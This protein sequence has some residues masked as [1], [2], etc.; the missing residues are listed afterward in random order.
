MTSLFVGI[1]ALAAV[2]LGTAIV[3]FIAK[4]IRYRAARA[5]DLRRA[6]YINTLSELVSRFAIPDVELEGWR[7]DPVFS[8][9]LIEALDIFDG[10]QRDHLVEIARRIG[11]ADDLLKG[12]AS[13]RV[14]RRLDAV[15]ALSRIADIEHKAAIERALN[16]PSAE[17]RVQAAFALARIGSSDSVPK[18]IRRM[19]SEDLWAAQLMADALTEFGSSA[20][21]AMAADVLID[22]PGIE[23]QARYLPDLVRALGSIGDP[24][25]EP[26]L[27][28]A[29]GSDDPIIRLRAAEALGSSGTPTSVPKLMRTLDDDDW[30]VRVKAAAALGQQRD[31]R[32]LMNLRT[33]LR[34]PEWWVRQAA[35]EAIGRI[36]GGDQVLIDALDDDDPF[37][38]DAAVE[39]LTL[40]GAVRQARRAGEGD[41]LHDKLVAMGRGHL[42][43]ES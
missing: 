14:G 6:I 31:A 40:T 7:K 5:R 27:L 8:E 11:L 21:A 39:R 22:R 26:A 35:A 36:G 42:V 19:N 9:R 43:S 38:R 15:T 29:L 25:A 28:H 41:R 16:D 4:Y 34:D 33:A 18:I 37:A 17:V 12:L 32:G 13:K 23:G 10:A 24:T 1:I 3:F 20:V 30:R 2:V